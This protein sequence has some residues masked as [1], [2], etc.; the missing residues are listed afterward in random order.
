MEI[1]MIRE[2][3]TLAFQGDIFILEI[4]KLPENA[5]KLNKVLNGNDREAY[6]YHA[7][8]GLVL[9]QGESRQHYHAFRETEEV[10]LWHIPANDNQREK[11]YVVLKSPQILMHE[12]HDG[13]Q[14]NAGVH[15]FGFQF[16][17]TFED[18]TRR[19]AD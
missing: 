18:E 11:L 4:D 12:E 13:I 1:F 6:G 7:G 14:R 19:V 17:A 10:E 15:R 8:K 16:E 3:T 9:A 2:A 5:V